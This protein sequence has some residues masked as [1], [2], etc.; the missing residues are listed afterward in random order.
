MKAA[1]IYA[2]VSSD[3]QREDKTITS[4]TAAV[5]A[6]ASTQGYSVPP[7]SLRVFLRVAGASSGL[8]TLGA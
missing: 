7:E 4:Q 1:A 8:A 6:F 3:Q 2:R 5:M